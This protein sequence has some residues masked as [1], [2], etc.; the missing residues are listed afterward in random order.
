MEGDH[1]ATGAR[2]LCGDPGPQGSS[3]L[4]GDPGARGCKC[5]RGQRGAKGDR[6]PRGTKGD[7]GVKGPKG[8][9]GPQGPKGD[10]GD[11][12]STSLPTVSQDLSMQGYRIT[13]MGA[14]TSDSDAATRKYVEDKPRGISRATADSLYLGSGGG[15]LQGGVPFITPVK[16]RTWVIL[17]WP[18]MQLISAMFTPSC[19][20]AG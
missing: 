11:P 14:P 1:G 10:K 20:K 9:V 5:D 2:G 7:I 16:L 12:G 3:G 4:R 8:D 15:T 18:P 6:G 17:R 13:Q 19:H